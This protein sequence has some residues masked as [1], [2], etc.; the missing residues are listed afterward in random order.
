MKD[1]ALEEFL[2]E[3]ETLCRNQYTYDYG[4]MPAG[5]CNGHTVEPYHGTWHSIVIDGCI[6]SM[7]V[8]SE[9]YPNGNV[10]YITNGEERTALEDVRYRLTR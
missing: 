10:I 7:A 5:T 8:Y 4:R 2:A 1:W 6:H 9:K 3:C